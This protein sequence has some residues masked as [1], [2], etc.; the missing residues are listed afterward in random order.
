[1]VNN[2]MTNEQMLNASLSDNNFRIELSDLIEYVV[3]DE[4][5][6]YIEIELNNF[7]LEYKI[8]TPLNHGHKISHISHISR[9]IYFNMYENKNL[10][11]ALYFMF[12]F[13]NNI[14]DKLYKLRTTIDNENR[15]KY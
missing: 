7:N 11:K 5:F 10:N 6:N 3:F 15:L 13:N 1:M 12:G 8:L 4:L 9:K 14:H 2:I